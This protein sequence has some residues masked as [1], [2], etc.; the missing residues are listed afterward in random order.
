[1]HNSRGPLAVY[2]ALALVALAFILPLLWMVAVSFKPAAEASSS[3]LLP[4]DP[5]L[6]AYQSIIGVDFGNASAAQVSQTSRDLG[7]FNYLLYARNTLLILVLSLVG[8]LASSSIAAY[9]FARIEFP[10][11]K[12]LF[13]ICLATMMIPFPVIMVPTYM[14]FKQLGWIGTFMP[15]W[16]PAWFAS[17]FNV[18]L[19]RQFFMGIPRDLEESA[20]LD[21][22]SRWG[23]FWRIIIPLSTPALAVVALFHTLTVWNDLVGP[24]IYLSYQ[25]QYTLALGLQFLQSRSGDTPWNEL[26]AASTLV[27]LPVV[28]LFLLAQRS[29]IEG[30]SATGIKG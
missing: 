20:M 16:V 24:L 2:A 23:C 4:R 18:F 14:I 8:V 12:L 26:M 1:M 11:R 5:T 9:G 6:N 13:G 21:G 27:I 29:F 3:A 28:V 19:L 22:C 10:G 7:R 30:V 15:L 25:D 17:A